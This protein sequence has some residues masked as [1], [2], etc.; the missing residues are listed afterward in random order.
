MNK[1]LLG[2]FVFMLLIATGLQT[3]GTTT[4]KEKKNDYKSLSQLFFT[5]NIGQFSFTLSPRPRGFHIK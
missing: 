2:I 1:K 5:K 4:L 3:Q